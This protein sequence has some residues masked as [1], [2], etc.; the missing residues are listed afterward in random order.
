MLS[1][2][3]LIAGNKLTNECGDNKL[4]IYYNPNNNSFCVSTN[5]IYHQTIGEVGFRKYDDAVNHFNIILY[6]IET[7]K[8]EHNF[9]HKY[10]IGDK[11]I[12]TNEFGVC[13][14]IKEI[15][16][17]TFKKKRDSD[18]YVEKYVYKNQ[19]SFWF[20]NDVKYFTT[21][22]EEDLIKN[23]KCDLQHFQNK[24]G[25]ITPQESLNALLDN[26]PFEFMDK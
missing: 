10:N 13:F 25:F 5:F 22:T 19:G 12:Y 3:S 11:V 17:V 14:G 9:S 8:Q 24:Y 6:Y 16:Q 26:D 23:K 21:P 20:S 7:A 1:K 18:I 15:I 4:S 2:E